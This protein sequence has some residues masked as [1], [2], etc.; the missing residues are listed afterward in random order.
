MEILLI[1][2]KIKF[3][4]TNIIIII[5]KESFETKIQKNTNNKET[6]N[7]AIDFC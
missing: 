4:F 2:K 3:V 6:L 7:I 5:S 1:I